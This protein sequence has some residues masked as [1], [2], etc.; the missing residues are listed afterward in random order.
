MN[1]MKDLRQE[2][3]KFKERGVSGRGT[4]ASWPP[5]RRWA[6]SKVITATR[7][8]MDAADLRKHG[9]LPAG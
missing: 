7:D 4:A 2:L 3:E 8:G 6:S 1:E 5:P 9:R